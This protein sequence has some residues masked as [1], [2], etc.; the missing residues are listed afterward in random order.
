MHT[1]VYSILLFSVTEGAIRPVSPDL[2]TLCPTLE[3]PCR[4][5]A[6]ALYM[7]LCV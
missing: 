7:C 6:V 3:P 4:A 1:A 2:K 5:P